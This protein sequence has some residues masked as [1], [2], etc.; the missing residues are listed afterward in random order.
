MTNTKKYMHIMKPHEKL[1]RY[2]TQSLD[3]LELASLDFAKLFY[4]VRV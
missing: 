2:Y 3:S 1:K 4:L